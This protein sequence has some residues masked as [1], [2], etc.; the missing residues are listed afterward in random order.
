MA[1]RV[2]PMILLLAGVVALAAI[3]AE[4]QQQPKVYRL[5]CLW[6]VPATVAGPYLAALETGLRDLGWVSGTN[7]A[8]EHRFPESPADFPRLAASVVAARV[9]A[10]AAM[11]NPVVAAAASATTDIPIVGVYTSD[12]ITAGFAV[13]MARP[14]KNITG[15]SMDASP[16]LYGK[17]LELLKQ[18]VPRAQLVQVLRNPD[19]YGSPLQQVYITTIERAARSLKLEIYFSDVRN[20]SEIEQALRAGAQKP[21]SAIYAMPELV[22]FLHGPLIAKLAADRRLPAIFGFREPVEAGALASYGPDLLSMPRHAATFIDRLFRGARASDL[23]Y[24]QPTKF[25]LVINA[26]AARS[27][28][29]TIAPSVRLRADRLIE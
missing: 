18:L 27:L 10:I 25:E 22:T 19:W 14:G 3:D 26:K 13:T 20:A 7:I 4:A 28:G 12:P 8:F 15:L 23:P 1:I 11:T 24:E 17:Q 21:A 16:D 9:D 2:I 5:G 29:L 6:A